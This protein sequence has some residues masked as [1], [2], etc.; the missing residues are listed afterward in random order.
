MSHP[1]MRELEATMWRRHANPKSGWTRLP[2]GAALVYAVYT[3]NVRLLVAV[4]AW[5]AINP[6]L[7][8]P[9][10]EADAWMTRAVRAEQWWLYEQENATVGIDYP[11]VANAVGA[12]GFCCALAAAWRR[13]PAGA[14][15]GAIVSVALKLW[16][17]R[18][19][20][21]RYDARPAGETADQ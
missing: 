1:E 18:V 12:L 20:V 4:L 17:L 13:R 9:P 11:N 8:P 5:I 3:R 7:F 10:D 14:A 6:F 21:S 16:W 2:S 19:L 15:V